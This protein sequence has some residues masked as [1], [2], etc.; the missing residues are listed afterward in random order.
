MPALQI[1]DCPQDVYVRLKESAAREN[2]NISQQML[3]IIERYLDAQDGAFASSFSGTAESAL[4]RSSSFLS[5]GSGACQYAEMRHTQN[6]FIEK[7][8][9]AFERISKLPPVKLNDDAATIADLV[10]ESR[11][12][13]R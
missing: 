8:Q 1:K 12:E 6:D 4:D 5:W 3:S 10:L 13:A 11:D 9:A 2:R 7:R